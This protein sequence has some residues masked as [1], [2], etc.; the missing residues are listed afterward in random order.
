MSQPIVPDQVVACDA[1]H[2]HPNERHCES[3]IFHS[4]SHVSSSRVVHFLAWHGACVS[5]RPIVPH[6]RASPST[7]WGGG[8]GHRPAGLCWCLRTLHFLFWQPCH[9]IVQYY[10]TRTRRISGQ[11]PRFNPLPHLLWKRVAGIPLTT[12]HRALHHWL[13]CE[14]SWVPSPR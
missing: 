12:L 1:N 4:H 9:S 6:V 11:V 8:Q 10:A 2:M 14:L 3:F 13:C 5:L 7:L